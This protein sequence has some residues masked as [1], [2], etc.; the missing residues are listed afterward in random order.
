MSIHGAYKYVQQSRM[1]KVTVSAMTIAKLVCCA[2]ATLLTDNKFVTNR[3]V[4]EDH[5]LIIAARK[6]E[7]KRRRRAW[8]DPDMDFDQSIYEEFNP[9]AACEVKQQQ[10]PSAPGIPVGVDKSTTRIDEVP[11]VYPTIMPTTTLANILNNPVTDNPPAYLRPEYLK[12]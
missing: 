8:I 5:Q 3:Q 9:Y 4:I 2:P 12:P 1:A 7:D 6:R 10:D 11:F